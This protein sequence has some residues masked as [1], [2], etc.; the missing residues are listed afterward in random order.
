MDS[1]E[2]EAKR[3]LQKEKN[4]E[5]SKRKHPKSNEKQGREDLEKTIPES[6]KREKF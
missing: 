3:S 5:K 2:D 1:Q 6:K 4:T